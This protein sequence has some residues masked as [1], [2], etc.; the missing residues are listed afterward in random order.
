MCIFIFFSDGG[1]G[2]AIGYTSQLVTS[3]VTYF[4]WQMRLKKLYASYYYANGKIIIITFQA[5][6]K[7][8]FSMPLFFFVHP[9]PPPPPTLFQPPLFSSISLYLLHIHNQTPQSFFPF[10]TLTVH[11]VA[12]HKACI[13]IYSPSPLH[14]PFFSSRSEFTPPPPPLPSLP[15]IEL[16]LLLCP[17]I[18]LLFLQYSMC[19]LLS[20]FYHSPPPPPPPP[21]PRSLSS[22]SVWL[23]RLYSYSPSSLGPFMVSFSSSSKYTKTL[24]MVVV[25]LQILP[26]VGGSSKTACRVSKA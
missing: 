10:L 14:P 15:L 25:L 26:V 2:G 6:L 3:F 19:S 16:A 20:F 11:I 1:R 5:K 23:W 22:L 8:L 7:S 18:S 24:I 17:L 9:P 21:P 13:H 12:P 4:V